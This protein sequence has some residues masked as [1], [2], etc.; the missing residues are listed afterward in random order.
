MSQ[1]NEQSGESSVD[2]DPDFPTVEEILAS[3][4]ID[5]SGSSNATDMYERAPI[6]TDTCLLGSNARD[7]DPV[8]F[9]TSESKCFKA[10]QL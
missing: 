8:Q 6:D 3:T 9:G 1:D 4:R 10:L 2:T 7:F 5:P